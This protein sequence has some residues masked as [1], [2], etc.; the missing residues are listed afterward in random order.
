MK[1]QLGTGHYV[2]VALL[3]L[4]GA[5]LYL[6]KLPVPPSTLAA[7]GTAIVAALSFSIQR[8]ILP[9]A[10]SNPTLAAP[11]PSQLPTVP[12]QGPTGATG[13]G[14]DGPTGPTAAA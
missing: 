13:A 4:S 8:S 7:W 5:L 14:P 6:A 1:L 10:A 12:P 2:S 9:N 11:Q 3:I